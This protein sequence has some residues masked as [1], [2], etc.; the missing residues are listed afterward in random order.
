MTINCVII[1]DEPLAVKLLEN[2]ISKIEEMKVVGTG[3][4]A[5]EAYRI[6][7]DRQVDLL[8]LDIRMPDLSG[9]EFLRSLNHKPKTIFTTAYRDYAVEGFELEAVD[10]LLKP[11]T[12]DRFFKSVQ[13]ILT[14]VAK[15]TG[16]EFFILK[17]EGFNKKILLKDILY[18]ESSGNDI[19]IYL[20]NEYITVSK[21][22]LSELA[23]QLLKKGFI[24]IHRSFM[25]NVSYVTAIGSQE[26]LVGKK[27][28]PIGRSY[29][30][31]FDAF[32]KAFLGKHSFN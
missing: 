3:K 18:L 10:Y 13:R 12:F 1:D 15:D 25:I 19:K 22:T 32:K 20:I 4:N 29:K 17:S 6:L 28:I 23:T 26:I 31:E 8:F 30:N 5:M 2:H 27:G 16:E 9:I 7:Q 24:R 21:M 11:I 14:T